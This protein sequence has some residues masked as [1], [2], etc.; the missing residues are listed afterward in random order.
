MGLAILLIFCSLARIDAAFE[1]NWT[2]VRTQSLGDSV[3]SLFQMSKKGPR[4]LLVERMSILPVDLERTVIAGEQHNDKYHLGFYWIRFGDNEITPNLAYIEDT[5]AI[6]STFFLSEKISFGIQFKRYL[7]ESI[8]LGSGIG[9]DLGIQVS[10]SPKFKLGFEF[11]ELINQVK[12][13]TGKIERAP[14]QFNVLLENRLRKDTELFLSL[15]NEQEVNFGCEFALIPELD[16]RAGLANGRWTGGIC[17]YQN[18][19]IFEYGLFNNRL[20]KQQILSVS[21]SF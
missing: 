14:A 1:N 5:K 7:L 21:K 12:Y 18:N 15:N 2:S 19:W 13:E 6:R 4:A 17:I 16:L 8:K 3:S 11:N 20:G 9:L 10:L